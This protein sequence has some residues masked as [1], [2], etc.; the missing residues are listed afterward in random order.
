MSRWRVALRATQWFLASG[1]GGEREIL[2]F[3][4]Q[5]L[6]KFEHGALNKFF[7]DVIK[8][9]LSLAASLR[10]RLRRH[11]DRRRMSIDGECDRGPSR[12]PKR[13]HATL[14]DFN[15]RALLFVVAPPHRCQAARCESLFANWSKCR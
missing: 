14:I 1:G 12:C 11:E 4:G 9:K 10:D 7:R 5:A 2:S 15:G 3:G 8:G 6:K 13:V